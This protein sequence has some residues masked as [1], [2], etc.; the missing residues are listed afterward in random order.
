MSRLDVPVGRQVTSVAMCFPRACRT[1]SDV[2]GTVLPTSLYDIIYGI[3][4]QWIPTFYAFSSGADCPK[5][6]IVYASLSL[7]SREILKTELIPAIHIL[8]Q[9]KKRK[10]NLS[11]VDVE[12]YTN[13]GIWHQFLVVFLV[14]SC[15]PLC[16]YMLISDLSV[17]GR[18]RTIVNQTNIGIVSNGNTGETPERQDEAH[19]Y[20]LSRAHR[21]HLELNWTEVHVLIHR[22]I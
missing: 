22:P 16:S 20:G 18:E 1:S 7:Y 4:F 12:V 21:Y 3:L 9:K 10:V 2:R 15:N 13:R 19:K 14:S 5:W 11:C 8:K 17:R 6:S